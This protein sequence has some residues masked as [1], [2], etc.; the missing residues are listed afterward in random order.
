LCECSHKGELLVIF[1][2]LTTTFHPYHDGCNT[3]LDRYIKLSTWHLNEIKV[4]T[5]LNSTMRAFA[6]LPI[7]FACGSVAELEYVDFPHLIIPLKQDTPDSIYGTQTTGEV[8][9]SVYTEV[10]FDVPNDVPASICRINFAINTDPAKNAPRTLT[11]Q[12]PYTFFVYHT[13]ATI[14]K[15][16]DT[17]NSHPE[18]TNYVATITLTQGGDVTVKDGW[19]DCPKGNV[20]Q[21]LLVP[22]GTRAF[23]YTWY[24]LNYPASAGGPHGITLEMHS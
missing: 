4:S 19:F 24:E 10:S 22:Q 12:A 1:D 2:A 23:R 9:N 3:C 7:L 21:F 5:L 17:W 18:I 16:K 15:D 13:E 11:G 14:D 6:L 8:S 20:A